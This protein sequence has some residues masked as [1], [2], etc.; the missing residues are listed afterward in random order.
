MAMLQC[1]PH[2]SATVPPP[3]QCYSAT[4]TA[5]LQCHPHGSAT[6]PLPW[7]CYSATPMAVLHCHPDIFEAK[8]NHLQWLT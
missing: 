5:V 4:P 8:N 1:H 7:Q 2:G 6:M 3:W